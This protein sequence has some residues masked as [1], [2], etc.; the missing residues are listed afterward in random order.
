MAGKNYR[1]TAF[2]TADSDFTIEAAFT[3]LKR[4]YLTRDIC[5]EQIDSDIKIDFGSWFLTIS[6]LEGA[7]DFEQTSKT[8]A[9]F[10]VSNCVRRVH[11][12]SADPYPNLDHFNDFLV[13][14]EQITD[15]FGGVYT[16]DDDSGR[17]Y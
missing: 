1:A 14:A 3:K 12:S 9:D 13:V 7:G 6:E 16:R 2:I 17:W 15:S 8:P 4:K 10:E 11:M 5:V